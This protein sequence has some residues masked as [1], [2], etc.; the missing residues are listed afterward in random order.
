VP[1]E[2]YFVDA[3]GNGLYDRGEQFANL[4]EAFVDHNEDGVYTPT[5]GPTQ[6][7]ID[8][9]GRD[10]CIE[11][12]EEETFVD[13]NQDGEYSLNVDPNTGEGVYNGS[14]CPE[15]GDGVYCS[16]ELVSTRNEVVVVMSSTVWVATLVNRDTG[17][18]VGTIDD[19][20]G[21]YVFYVSDEFN[22]APAEGSIIS[23]TA[24]G[25]TV[26]PSTFNV[27]TELIGATEVDV[28][29]SGDGGSGKLRVF[30][31]EEPDSPPVQAEGTFTCVTTA[32]PDPNEDG[33]TIGGG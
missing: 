1:G 3:N 21:D 13:F 15:E 32:P 2:E 31:Q 30:V 6:E 7:C 9:F 18:A 16:R 24:S 28:S 11:S 33:L 8:F 12:G 25:C 14:L 29:V 20:R 23:F 26:E 22:N 5:E 17:R 4:P 27:P 19:G 10:R